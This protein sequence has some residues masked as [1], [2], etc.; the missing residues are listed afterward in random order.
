MAQMERISC[1]IKIFCSLVI[2]TFI[3]MIDM[4]NFIKQSFLKENSDSPLKHED[5]FLY[6][7]IIVKQSILAKERYS[8]LLCGLH[9]ACNHIFSFT[10]ST[11]VERLSRDLVSHKCMYA[12]RTYF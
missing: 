1:Q 8:V 9:E 11:R 4:C 7:F 5:F 6:N 10:Q 12:L 3:L 2:V